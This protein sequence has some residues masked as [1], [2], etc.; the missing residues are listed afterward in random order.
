MGGVGPPVS[1]DVVFFRKSSGEDV[2]NEDLVGKPSIKWETL[3]MAMFDY[4]RGFIL[5]DRLFK[6]QNLWYSHSL[7]RGFHG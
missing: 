5:Y 7:F 2:F 6:H 3:Y 4:R 1:S